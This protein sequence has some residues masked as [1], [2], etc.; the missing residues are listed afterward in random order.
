MMLTHLLTIQIT[1]PVNTTAGPLLI[2]GVT[3]Q[4][5]KTVGSTGMRIVNRKVG[6]DQGLFT[7][8]SRNGASVVD[9]LLCK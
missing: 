4:R 1:Y 9:Y 3:T 7:F 6:E 5:Y 2:Q 8:I